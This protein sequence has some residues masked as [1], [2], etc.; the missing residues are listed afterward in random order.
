[1]PLKETNSR[2]DSAKFTILSFHVFP[3]CYV[4]EQHLCLFTCR[5][6]GKRTVCVFTS[7]ELFA[8]GD[9]QE[10]AVF[11]ETCAISFDMFA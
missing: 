11:T 6:E 5:Q 10:L 1:M 4:C 7:H 3:C 9:V 2:A 8:D